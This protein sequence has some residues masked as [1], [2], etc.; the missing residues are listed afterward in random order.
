MH[1]KYG[2]RIGRSL[3]TS[4]TIF[5]N[6]PTNQTQPNKTQPKSL[7][8]ARTRA[9]IVVVAIAWDAYKQ[10]WYLS[11][12]VPVEKNYVMS[13]M[14]ILVEILYILCEEKLSQN[15]FL[16][17]KMTNIMW[18]WWLLPKKRGR[19]ANQRWTSNAKHCR[20][21][22]GHPSRDDFIRSEKKQVHKAWRCESE[23]MNQWKYYI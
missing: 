13:C 14:Y 9:L 11:Q 10:I 1:N 15:C 18:R 3:V 21:C 5:L 2:C 6:K 16:W 23:T 12:P 17:I 8:S 19:E 7:F 20:R 4:E 22:S